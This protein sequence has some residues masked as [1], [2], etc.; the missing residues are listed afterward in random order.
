MKVGDLVTWSGE[1]ILNELFQIGV[2]FRCDGDGYVHIQWAD[3]DP[4]C[5]SVEHERDLKEIA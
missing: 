3:A 2:I 4:P 5:R 1:V